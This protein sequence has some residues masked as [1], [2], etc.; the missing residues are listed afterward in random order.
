M[1]FYMGL[2]SSIVPFN[3]RIFIVGCSK[4]VSSQNPEY[5]LKLATE[6]LD[7]WNIRS[8]WLRN[9]STSGK[10]AQHG[11]RTAQHLEYP[12]NLY[13]IIF[14]KPPPKSLKTTA[15]TIRIIG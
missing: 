11:H 1:V 4:V 14:F 6:P 10:S 5:P 12:L 7:N 8:T 13:R 2:D 3:E 15:L 9:R